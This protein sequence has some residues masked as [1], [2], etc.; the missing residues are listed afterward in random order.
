M[1]RLLFLGLCFLFCCTTDKKTK[2]KY[3]DI[4]F[5]E[6]IA[7]KNHERFSNYI[8]TERELNGGLKGISKIKIDSNFYSYQLYLPC[9]NSLINDK[10]MKFDIKSYAKV[11]SDHLLDS[12]AV[13]VFL[14]DDNF[15]VKE[16]FRFD[17]KSI[18][19]IR[20]ISNGYFKI[21]FP[22]NVDWHIPQALADELRVNQ[23]ELLKSK[24]TIRIQ[25]ED[26]RESVSVDIYVD[27]NEVNLDTLRT[28]FNNAYCASL[29]YD[30][31]FAYTPTYVN[32]RDKKTKDVK[33][34]NAHGVRK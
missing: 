17:S 27:L 21:T 14:T 28:Q 15:N 13:H 16:S 12:A 4:Y 24:D 9:E 1:N 2:T 18:H 30:I 11:M 8:D 5:T 31:L 10:K 33:F 25:I 32:V 22:E 26:K 3:F 23:P 34:V 6:R 7:V 29:I 19:Y 20:T